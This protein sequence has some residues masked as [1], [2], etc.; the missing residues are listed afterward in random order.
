MRVLFFGVSVRE[1]LRA[2]AENNQTYMEKQ[3]N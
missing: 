2:I 3:A 1:G